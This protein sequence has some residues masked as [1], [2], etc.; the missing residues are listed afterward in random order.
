MTYIILYYKRQCSRL[1][2]SE[3]DRRS[4][5]VS[6]ERQRRRRRRHESLSFGPMSLSE[7]VTS[8]MRMSWN[9]VQDIDDFEE[10][11]HEENTVHERR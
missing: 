7:S 3:G 6:R 9:E 4:R 10:E 5:R 2:E 11:D 1:D 8:S